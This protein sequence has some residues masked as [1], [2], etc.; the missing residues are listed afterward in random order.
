MCVC[1]IVCLYERLWYGVLVDPDRVCW[2][3]PRQRWALALCLPRGTAH[4]QGPQSPGQ[5]PASHSPAGHT[6]KKDPSGED[7]ARCAPRLRSGRATGGR[8]LLVALG[9]GP[10]SASGARDP[11]Q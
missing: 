6:P 11:L 10:R 7:T 5:S 4:C 3:R 9:P 2:G 1:L 8:S